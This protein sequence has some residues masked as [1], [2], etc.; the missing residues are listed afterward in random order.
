MKVYPIVLGNDAKTDERA[1]TLTRSVTAGHPCPGRWY[2][3]QDVEDPE[4]VS[5]HVWYP[6]NFDCSKEENRVVF[7]EAYAAVTFEQRCLVMTG[8]PECEALVKE[9]IFKCL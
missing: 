8:K 3:G 4:G 6:K 1:W 2:P 9:P 7:V 5:L